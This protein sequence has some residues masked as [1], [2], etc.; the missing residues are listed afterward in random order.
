MGRECSKLFCAVVLGL[1]H[2]SIGYADVLPVGSAPAAIQAKHF[3][4][5]L[6][7]SNHYYYLPLDLVEK[8]I[9]CEYILKA[10]PL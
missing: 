9:N 6:G 3:P 1:A 8:V 10:W 4:D 7:A 5:R 2:V